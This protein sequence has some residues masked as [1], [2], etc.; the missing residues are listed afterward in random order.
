MKLSNLVNESFYKRLKNKTFDPFYIS[1]T[2]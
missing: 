1:L 2:M